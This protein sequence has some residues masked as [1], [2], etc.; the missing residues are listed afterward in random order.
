MSPFPRELLGILGKQMLQIFPESCEKYGLRPLTKEER[1]DLE[2]S[3]KQTKDIA[4]WKRMFVILSYDDGLSIDELA[5]LTRLSRWTVEDYLKKYSSQNK[6]KNDPRG[7]SSSKLTEAEAKDL[8]EHLSK[9][10]Y[11]KVKDIVSYAGER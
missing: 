5:K 6:T 11:L 9:T 8:E 4:D 3:L 1:S 2:K 7:G 10:T